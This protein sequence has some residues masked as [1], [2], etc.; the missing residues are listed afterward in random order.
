MGYTK[1]SLS[2]IESQFFD[3]IKKETQTATIRQKYNKPLKNLC[4]DLGVD[5]V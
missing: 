3:C 2:A 1:I 4:N 5:Y